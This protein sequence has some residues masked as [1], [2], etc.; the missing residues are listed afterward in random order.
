MILCLIAI[1]YYS[2]LAGEPAMQ[3]LSW[4]WGGIKSHKK[5]TE[6]VI[7]S[8]FIFSSLSD[9]VSDREKRNYEQ[10]LI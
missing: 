8:I 3:Q 2:V 10:L 4:A 5:A 9:R 6:L 7:M 1:L